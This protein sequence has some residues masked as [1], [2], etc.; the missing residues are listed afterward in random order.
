MRKLLPLALCLLL[1]ASGPGQDSADP[2]A[3]TTASPAE[4]ANTEPLAVHGG[5]A[6]KLFN[7]S[8]GPFDVASFPSGRDKELRLPLRIRLETWE[9][10]ALEVIKRLDQLR[11]AETLA[12][13]RAECLAGAVG[14]RLVHSPVTTADASTQMSGESISEKI[15]PTEYEPPEFPGAPTSGGL[16]QK[17]LKSL[18]EWM[19]Q[20]MTSATPTSFETRDTGCKLTA[21]A[22]AVAVEE[23]S[24]D[25]AISF[26]DVAQTGAESFGHDSLRLTMPTFTAF[27]T[28]GL[29]RL[30]EGQWR[31][32]SVME[33]PRGLDG[34]PSDKRWVTLVRI[35]PEG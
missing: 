10:P 2:F 18:P 34:K 15:Y 29:I 26:E 7:D 5:E 11:G 22:Q 27:R 20:I 23:R 30:K 19:E 24:W 1:P 6:Q 12:A 14:V 28:G 16:G 25:L 4:P 33:P 3:E 32:L 9:A 21:L 17:P 8:D 35:D 31:L 13:L